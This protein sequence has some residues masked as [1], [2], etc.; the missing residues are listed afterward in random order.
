MKHKNIKKALRNMFADGVCVHS[1]TDG[2]GRGV[3]AERD[4]APHDEVV[5][6]PRDRLITCS[7]AVAAHP[8][9]AGH[10][11]VATLIRFLMKEERAGGA[12]AWASYMADLPLEFGCLPIFI[13][14]RPEHFTYILP[15][16]IVEALRSQRSAAESLYEG[17][18][19]ECDDLSWKQFIRWWAVVNTRCVSMHSRKGRDTMALAPTLDMFNHSCTTESDAHYDEARQGYIV[20]VGGV[21]KSGEQVFI[22]YGPHSN[23]KLLMEYGFVLAGNPHSTVVVESLPRSTEQSTTCPKGHKLQIQHGMLKRH[24][25]QTIARINSMT[26]LS[27][28]F[29]TWR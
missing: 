23:A 3:I 6:V 18:A 11:E 10:G 9:L 13:G 7:S 22:S 12:S 20:R 28:C 29:D 17:I 19:K 4:L 5:F 15:P 21:V 27:R 25:S 16:D 26:A 8:D 14:A 2:T 1:F 24:R